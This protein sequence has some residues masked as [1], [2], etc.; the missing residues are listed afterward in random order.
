MNFSRFPFKTNQKLL[1]LNGFEPK[2]TRS[3]QYTALET[4]PEC[5]YEID[6]ATTLAWKNAQVT[7]IPPKM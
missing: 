2:L 5:F 6:N 7:P 4:E 3:K 1:D